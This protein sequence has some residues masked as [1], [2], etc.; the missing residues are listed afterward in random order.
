MICI[1]AVSP[2]GTGARD[3][4]GCEN[5]SE[6]EAEAHTRRT[7]TTAALVTR[8]TS[9]SWVAAALLPI[10]LS[11]EFQ[12]GPKHVFAIGQKILDFPLF[13]DQMP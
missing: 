11:A 7:D 2:C 13:R 4:R 3:K 1:A 6:T 5:D 12:P 10:R 8:N 9:M